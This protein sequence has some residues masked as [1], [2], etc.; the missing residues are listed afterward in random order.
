MARL[1][2]IGIVYTPPCVAQ[3]VNRAPLLGVAAV[4]RA[5]TA[6]CPSESSARCSD[7]CGL[8]AVQAAR[9]SAAALQ[10][11]ARSV[12]PIDERSPDGDD[13]SHSRHVPATSFELSRLS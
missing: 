1:V 8:W 11:T 3:R 4:K 10:L 13:E 5:R 7:A 12:R 9:C 6:S 2:G